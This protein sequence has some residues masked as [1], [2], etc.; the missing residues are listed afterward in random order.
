MARH[1]RGMPLGSFPPP[2]W[3]VGITLLKENVNTPFLRKHI[4]MA[5]AGFDHDGCA[6]SP[7]AEN[8]AGAHS[9]THSCPG[10][11]VGALVASGSSAAPALTPQGSTR[12]SRWSEEQ[13]WPV[14]RRGYWVAGPCLLLGAPAGSSPL[15]VL[16]SHSSCTAPLRGG[17]EGHLEDKGGRM[18]TETVPSEIHFW[19]SVC[20]V[21]YGAL[22]I[23][24]TG[25]PCVAFTGLELRSS[26]LHL[27]GSW[28]G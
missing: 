10:A 20:G 3:N 12:Q 25:Y 9:S 18:G 14:Q 15:A 21:T 7:P 26:C 13:Q 19:G 5:G 4:N 6:I 11:A 16:P 23:F 2:R 28:D 8:R 27:L 22:S 17:L 24:E 1:R